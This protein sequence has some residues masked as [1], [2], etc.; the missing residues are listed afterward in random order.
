ML[1][2]E[3]KIYVQIVSGSSLKPYQTFYSHRKN[4]TNEFLAQL[5]YAAFLLQPGSAKDKKASLFKFDDDGI[6][7]NK[8]YKKI[9]NYD[10]TDRTKCGILIQKTENDNKAID[11]VL[12]VAQLYK[13]S[14]KYLKD[15]LVDLKLTYQAMMDNSTEESKR[16]KELSIASITNRL[17]I[18]N[19]CM[20]YTISFFYAHREIDG[21]GTSGNF[22]FENYYCKNSNRIKFEK[23]LNFAKLLHIIM[24][25]RKLSSGE[26]LPISGRF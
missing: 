8:E 5:A 4:S 3:P 19:I 20:F 10:N 21:I 16:N 7:M 2:R 14:K 1:S 11:E 6:D 15:Y 25:D 23:I 17:D 24:I 13:D 9:F 18:N 12:F 26:F 22:D